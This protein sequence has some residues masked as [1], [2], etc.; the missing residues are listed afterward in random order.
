MGTHFL[1][2]KSCGTVCLI[3]FAHND[4]VTRVEGWGLAI[5]VFE[6]S[7]PFSA[8]TVEQ[9]EEVAL[10]LEEWQN[11]FCVVQCLL[12]IIGSTVGGGLVHADVDWEWEFSADSCN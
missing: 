6:V 12:A 1:C 7:M 3:M 11:G 2:M 4:D 5:F 9:L 10:V 8:V